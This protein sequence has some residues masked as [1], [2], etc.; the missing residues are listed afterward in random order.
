M[1]TALRLLAALVAVAV[2]GC[3]ASGLGLQN[4]VEVR[5]VGAG[6]GYQCSLQHTAGPDPV[7]ACWTVSV[8]CANGT[9]TSGSGCGEVQVGA[10][11][12]VLVPLSDFAGAEA[13]DLA[14]GVTVAVDSVTPL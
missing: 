1:K 8:T 11:S 6:I 3:G 7:R 12:T 4:R 10:T 2:L 14:T 13:C 9:R 5:C